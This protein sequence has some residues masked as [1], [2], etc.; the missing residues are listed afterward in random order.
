MVLPPKF[1]VAGSPDVDDFTGFAVEVTFT[2]GRIFTVVFVKEVLLPKDSCGS[3]VSGLVVW[4]ETLLSD[5]EDCEVASVRFLF[6]VINVLAVVDTGS[7][8]A[9]VV[10]VRW[11]AGLVVF[12]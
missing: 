3:G 5:T 10:V 12:S 9:V 6:W 4:T 11:S 8:V 7:W 1:A 2:A